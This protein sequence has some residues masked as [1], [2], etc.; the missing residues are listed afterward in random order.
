MFCPHCG[1]EYGENKIKCPACSGPLEENNLNTGK[2]QKIKFVTVYQA[3]DPAFLA[4]AK[5]ILQDEGI[6]YFFKGEGL[7]DLDGAGRLGTGF[8]TL[9]GPVEIQVDEHDAQK[10]RAILEQIERETAD[11]PETESKDEHYKNNSSPIDPEKKQSLK[12]IMLGILIGI[13]V[14]VAVYYIYKAIQH[15][16][17][18]NFTWYDYHDSNKDGKNDNFYYYDKGTL[19]RSESDD[20]FDGK[21]DKKCFFKDEVIDQ[22]LADDNY[23]GTFETKLFYQ[24]GIIHRVEYDYNSDKN[25]DVAESYVDG[26]IYDSVHYHESTGK[27]WE[28]VYYRYGIMNEE[29]ID[30]NGDG[31]FDI[32]IK[33]NEVGRP[34]R[35]TH[36]KK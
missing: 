25:T 28:K 23:D 2:P 12:G 32:S 4:F 24:K 31:M 9:F 20:N 21:V 14:S 29:Q 22:C 33:Y 8:N 15:Y 30:Q 5:S 13:A 26:V 6:P 19:I 35:T 11:M 3:G 18:K 1:T 36:L 10:A 7:Q 34:I 17:Y 16:Q 27:I